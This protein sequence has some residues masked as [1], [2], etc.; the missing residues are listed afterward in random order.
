MR[1]NQSCYV[2]HIRYEA[3][4]LNNYKISLEFLIL[5]YIN[6]TP[7]CIRLSDASRHMNT[8]SLWEQKIIFAHWNIWMYF[9]PL[10]LAIFVIVSDHNFQMQFCYWYQNHLSEANTVRCRYNAV[11]FLTNTHKRHPIARPLGRGMG[12][13]LWIQHL[14]NILPRFL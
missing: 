7:N 14:I 9:N 13:I 10:S 5:S 1:I 3:R 8:I 11:N 6:S 2:T 12:C 4:S